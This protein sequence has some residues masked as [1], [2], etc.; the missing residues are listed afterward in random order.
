VPIYDRTLLSS[1]QNER[2]QLLLS[3]WTWICRYSLV[4][5]WVGLGVGNAGY[6]HAH[7]HDD[8]K[9]YGRYDA[10]LWQHRLT[11]GFVLGASCQSVG[12]YT[13]RDY[14]STFNNQSAGCDKIRRRMIL[15]RS[16]HVSVI[17][18]A[19]QILTRVAI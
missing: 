5:M 13:D 8:V 17:T 18:E 11:L 1:W 2:N 7:C 4:D 14:R 3:D 6:Y 15:G 19:K 10:L 16:Q 12:L 9:A